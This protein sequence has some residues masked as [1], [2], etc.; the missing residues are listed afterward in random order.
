MPLILQLPDEQGRIV[1]YKLLAR[2]LTAPA[3][4]GFKSRIAYAAA[5]VVAD[6][7]RLDADGNPGVD[8]DST[9]A[10]RRHLW[11]LGFKVAEAMDTS[12]RG[13]GL[14]WAG[15]KELIARSLAEARA[16]PGAD[17]S[18]G[19]G[20]D[21]LDPTRAKSVHDVIAAYEEQIGFVEA[22]GGRAIMMASRA[23]ARVAKSPDDYVKVYDRI[24]S[25]ARDKVIL[26]WLGDM[27]D[28][29]LTG[30]WGS[31]DVAGAMDVVTS[32]I[33]ANRHKVEGIK[34]SLLDAS[35][36]ITLRRR[37]P[38]G[39]LMFT[40]DDFNYAELIAG[41]SKGH[42]HA[43]LGIFDPIAPAAALALQH[44]DRG[45]KKSFHTVL[46][47]TVALSRRIFEAPTW[48]YK[49]G[50]VF[51]AWLNGYQDHFTMIG[52]LQSARSIV[53]YADVFRLADQCGLLRDPDL[54][55]TRMRQLLAENGVHE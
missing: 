31:A 23:L 50:V 40:G 18:S 41:D 34:I 42:S 1:P 16:I 48:N 37:L 7:Q 33:A 45:D 14:S 43:L 4:R 36:E 38:K 29:Q 28:P 13:M 11:S 54:S 2:P 12:Q 39:V 30:Y 3:G 49:C 26:H 25:Q 47:P 9:M 19:V 17:L 46:D 55:M 10:F 51:L 52:G 24:L 27:F 44:L 22:Q 21:H 5:H 20:T 35:H 32:I 8:W 6:P 15:A 53:H